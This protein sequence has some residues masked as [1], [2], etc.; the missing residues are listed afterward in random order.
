MEMNFEAFATEIG[1]TLSIV[2][3]DLV[4]SVFS[5]ICFGI[6]RKAA[7]KYEIEKLYDQD[8]QRYYKE[9]TASPIKL[10][11]LFSQGTLEQEVTA[12]KALGIFLAAEKEAQLRDKLI[13]ILRKHDAVV[14][15]AVIKQDKRGLAKRYSDMDE[16]TL[17]L[18]ARID[19]SIY[20]YFCI[21]RSQEQLDLGFLKAILLDIKSYQSKNPVAAQGNEELESYRDKVSDIKKYLKQ[22]DLKVSN[23]KDVLISST[24]E[25]RRL[26]E[27]LQQLFLLNKLDVKLLFAQNEFNNLDKQLAA[28]VKV[29]GDAMDVDL[30]IPVL[31][32]GIF[33]QNLIDEYRNCRR[34]YFEN[35]SEEVRFLLEELKNKLSVMEKGDAEKAALLEDWKGR[36]LDFESSLHH[37]TE[38]LRKQHF[39]ELAEKDSI[40]RQLRERLEEEQVYKK[41]LYALREFIF[42]S[43]KNYI[44]E[45]IEKNFMN[46]VEDRKLLIIGGPKEWRRKLR[47]SY[48]GIRCLNGFNENFELG[49]LNNYDYIF[50]YTGFMNHATYYKAINF[51]RNNQ[52]KFG[53]IGKTNFDLVE[54]EIIDEIERLDSRG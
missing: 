18:E 1:S 29:Y 49:I 33:A 43:N 52:I 25:L 40:I 20:L 30:L 26:G 47:D 44:P 37:E 24:K 50:F 14:Y 23:Y 42:E 27:F 54:K 4:A 46:Y 51:I 9:M 36:Q 15:E 32:S 28:Y 17:K 19:S 34:S 7:M 41:E 21:Y 3:E 53:Y 10:S 12:R 6:S 39:E 38:K 31:A 16:L 13:R 8:G 11:P 5:N 22:K 2:P 48:A 45:N 35:S